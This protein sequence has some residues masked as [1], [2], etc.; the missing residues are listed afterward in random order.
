MICAEM[1]T[2]LVFFIYLIIFSLYVLVINLVEL[3]LL[4]KKQMIPRVPPNDKSTPLFR[5]L[6]GFMINMINKEKHILDHISFFLYI[7]PRN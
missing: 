7:I 6:Y 4:F 2:K 5:M 3:F 1:L